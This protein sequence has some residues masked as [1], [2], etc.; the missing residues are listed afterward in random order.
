MACS[1]AIWLSRRSRS[2]VALVRLVRL[3]GTGLAIVFLRYPRSSLGGASMIV[4]P[5]T[6][7]K[8]CPT[9]RAVAFARRRRGRAGQRGRAGDGKPDAVPVAVIEATPT[10]GGGLRARAAPRPRAGPVPLAA[11]RL[12]SRPENRN[13]T[14]ATG[15]PYVGGTP[16]CRELLAARVLAKMAR[17]NRLRP[18]RDRSVTGG[19]CVCAPR[20]GARRETAP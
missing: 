15:L 11:G 10:P 12:G 13:L 9:G 4:E 2:R 18:R 7:G 19:V 8:T 16:G 3:G 5:A 14:R 20:R 17:A 1:I 6:R